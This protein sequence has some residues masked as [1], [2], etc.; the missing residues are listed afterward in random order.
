MAT[1]RPQPLASRIAPALVWADE[2][3]ITGDVD[4]LP[5]LPS[6]PLMIPED[7][8][9]MQDLPSIASLY[10]ASL[11][12]KPLMD[13]K[14]QVDRDTA[15]YL[16]SC[17]AL[18]GHS[19]IPEMSDSS[20]MM[21]LK[22]EEPLLL[23]DHDMMMQQTKRRNEVTLHC[24]SLKHSNS[25]EA[26]MAD[27]SWSREELAY[28]NQI[29]TILEHEKLEVD[30][31]CIALLREVDLL[32]QTTNITTQLF[33]VDSRSTLQHRLERISPQPLPLSP[34]VELP[35]VDVDVSRPG[36]SSTGDSSAIEQEILDRE[37]FNETDLVDA[38][39]A[40]T[41]DLGNPGNMTVPDNNAIQPPETRFDLP[42]LRLKRKA[43]SGLGQDSPSQY[44]GLERTND[45]EVQDSIVDV[46]QSPADPTVQDMAHRHTREEGTTL[47]V[48][49]PNIDHSSPD[50]LWSACI[51]SGEGQG[52]ENRSLLELQKSAPRWPC[53]WPAPSIREIDLAWEPFPPRPAV[54]GIDED[55]DD[56][57]LAGCLTEMSFM[58]EPLQMET[59]ASCIGRRRE[60][61][62]QSELLQHDNIKGDA[63]LVMLDDACNKH[64]VSNS[65]ETPIQIS[66]NGPEDAP[67]QGNDQP[68][69][70]LSLDELLERHRTQLSRQN[71]EIFEG[72]IDNKLSLRYNLPGDVT[73]HVP[74]IKA[75]TRCLSP[76]QPLRTNF[77]STSLR[78]GNDQI[79]S[80]QERPCSSA[81]PSIAEDLPQ[82]LRIVIRPDT[83]SNYTLVR[84]LQR[85]LPS[86]DLIERDPKS[87]TVAVRS[88]AM[89]TVNAVEADLTIAPGVGIIT[90]TLQKLKQ[91]PLS[92]QQSSFTTIRDR[93]KAMVARYV[94]LIIFISEGRSA[95]N[96]QDEM[97]HPT[98]FQQLDGSDCAAF[99]E[100]SA[101]ATASCSPTVTQVIYIAGGQSELVEWM[102]V[103]IVQHAR[104]TTPDEHARGKEAFLRKAGSDPLAAQAILHML[105]RDKAEDGDSCVVPMTVSDSL[106]TTTSRSLD[107]CSSIAETGREA[108]GLHAFVNVSAADRLKT[109]SPLLGGGEA[110]EGVLSRIGGAVDRRWDS[111]STGP[112]RLH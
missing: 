68:D 71:P 29:D 84:N 81:V 73:I 16:A 80:P 15:E 90:A 72:Q 77:S 55:V 110:A 95:R 32:N 41:S 58:D 47:K 99:A 20:R 50:R 23:E 7:L 89:P 24:Y 57:S 82:D 51:L 93:V 1:D 94:K 97:F 108:H 3:C 78:C 60:Q 6:A 66:V 88:Q 49:V 9:D 38:Y 27:F 86:L 74:T 92:G 65:H 35:D 75:G 69:R 59:A 2:R 30:A 18:L 53:K 45:S 44:S 104:I 106:V 37:A 5:C 98:P 79:P 56:G 21:R 11:H 67:C 39:D 85:R 25:K 43:I 13:E 102:A 31:E 109:F 33:K 76:S 63:E 40:R 111:L 96:G 26:N 87:L 100:F 64:N 103:S 19:S 112:E 54:V 14:W 62:L 42:P 12:G 17:F 28:R 107:E 91:R 4:I 61:S 105:K 46:A 48:P 52:G 34:C 83:S 10:Q 22:L 8:E 70:T 101:F 36:I